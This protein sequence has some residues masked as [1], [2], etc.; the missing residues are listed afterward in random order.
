M[1]LT[2]LAV[3]TFTVSGV[4]KLEPSQTY[5]VVI[6]G[7]DGESRPGHF[8]QRTTSE[9]E[10]EDGAEG[11]TIGNSG[12]WK[13]RYSDDWS[14][15]TN[16]ARI[17]IRGNPLDP[18][19]S[20][21]TVAN[22]I[23]DQAATVGAAF[24]YTFAENTF[25]DADDDTLTYTATRAD[26]TDLPGW[27][28][29][30]AA[31]RTFSGTPQAGDVGTVSV[32]VAASDSQAD[33]EAAED[34]FD[35]VVSAAPNTAPTVA[36]AIPRPGGVG[37]HGVQLP[38]SGEHLQRRGQRHADVTRPPRPT[39]PA[40][41]GWLEF[42]ADTRTFSGTP[43]D[44]D[45][46]RLSVKVTARDNRGGS[47]SD[48]FDIMVAPDLSVLFVRVEPVADVDEG[49]AAQFTITVDQRAGQIPADG[50]EIAY[51]L[52]WA[53]HD[54]DDVDDRPHVAAEHLGRP[55]RH[56]RGRRHHGHGDGADHR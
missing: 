55:A 49:E 56:R 50:L 23:P 24:S 4:A 21:P 46:G 1:S 27:L 12:L 48:T 54:D 14:T 38:V 35:I 10:D 5:H 44:G 26:G 22:A 9:N 3:N 39:A 30:N 36:T 20:A 18:S 42:D 31:T 6:T 28:T 15:S 41:P 2:G 33:N 16:L 11:W 52:T 53:Q 40:L 45:V 13:N 7:L 25:S 8:I 51:E 29:F 19:N 17:E 43:Q 34:T 37:A 32:K 47:V